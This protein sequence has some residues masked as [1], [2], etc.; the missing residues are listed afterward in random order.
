MPRSVM[1]YPTTRRG[2]IDQIPL[3][4]TRVY[5]AYLDGTLMARA[6]K[7]TRDAE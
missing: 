1:P 3:G 4:P 6:S 5:L 7:G 2:R